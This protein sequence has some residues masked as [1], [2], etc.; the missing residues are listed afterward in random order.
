MA[1]AQKYRSLS[2]NICIE[3]LDQAEQILNGRFSQIKYCLDIVKKENLFERVIQI[4]YEELFSQGV[5]NL[6]II[7]KV[8]EFLTLQKL[9]NFSPSL[10]KQNNA[11]TYSKIINKQELEDRFGS[12]F[13]YLGDNSVEPKIW[14]SL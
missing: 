6:E 14:C 11:E 3:N 8:R 5:V 2:N 9:D 10:V 7:N 1:T 12:N 4:Q 13:G